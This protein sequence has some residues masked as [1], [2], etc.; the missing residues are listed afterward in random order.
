VQHDAR[1]DALERP[2]IEVAAADRA[3]IQENC[4]QERSLSNE[5]TSAVISRFCS[6]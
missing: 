6:S 5:S 3:E 2:G 1:Q 4:F